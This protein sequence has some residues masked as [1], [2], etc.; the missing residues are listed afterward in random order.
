MFTGDLGVRIIDLIYAPRVLLLGGGVP[1]QTSGYFYGGIDVSGA[2]AE[3]ISG[4]TDDLC[5]KAGIEA[6]REVLDF[7]A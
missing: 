7:A 1:I 6:I 3:K 5:A 2:P 4:D